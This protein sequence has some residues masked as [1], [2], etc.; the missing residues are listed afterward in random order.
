GFSES[1]CLE[2]MRTRLDDK[3][4]TLFEKN[5]NAVLFEPQVASAA[6]AF[7]SV[8]DRVRF[9]A[10]PDSIARDVLRHQS[11]LIAASLSTH[12]Q[13]WHEFGQKLGVDM[14]QP[15]NSVYDAI[16]MGWIAKWA[17]TD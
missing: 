5:R 12:I 11:A 7:A 16:A 17:S 3:A 14:N 10:I 6:Y 15:L 1:A 8:L 13:R 4:M 2:A 9:G